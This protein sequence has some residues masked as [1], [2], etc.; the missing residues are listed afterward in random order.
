MCHPNFFIVGAAKSGTT[1]LYEYLR[2]HPQVFLPD[3][4]EPVYFGADLDFDTELCI[5]PTIHNRAAYLKLYEG[6]ESYLRRGDATVWYL[7][8]QLAAREIHEFDPDAKI[9]IMLRNPLDVMVA[10]HQEFLWDCNEDLVDFAEAIAAQDDRRQGRRLGRTTHFRQG[11]L[12]EDVV[13]Y[14]DQVERYFD[15]FGR[16]HVCLIV[17]DDLVADDAAVFARVKEYLGLEMAFEPP[18]RHMNAR[19]PAQ[20]R[21][22]NQFFAARPRLRKALFSNV[23]SQTAKRAAIEVATRLFRRPNSDAPLDPQL[24]A[25]L[26]ERTRPQ[27]ARLSE[28]I[29]RDL[30]HWC[31]PV[32]TSPDGDE[33]VASA[34]D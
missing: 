4:K 29:G 21:R 32:A 31:D 26:V 18:H 11:L 14:A 7:Y 22:V 20:L 12:Y 1:S 33:G 13:A 2:Q 25:K 3:I 16:E 30:S 24:R 15:V 17:F 5:R 9:I 10:L 6:T 28:L 27:V 23:L 8:S 34:G 19:K